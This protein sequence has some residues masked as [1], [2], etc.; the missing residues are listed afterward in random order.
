MSH[1][2]S[3]EI[4]WSLEV[5]KFKACWRHDG[6][7]PDYVPFDQACPDCVITEPPIEV[8]AI[9]SSLGGRHHD[10]AE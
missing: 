3:V 2:A 6:R 9:P 8:A 10:E 4:R 1:D 7:N 5:Q